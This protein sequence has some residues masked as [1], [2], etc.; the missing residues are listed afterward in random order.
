MLFMVCVSLE[1]GSDDLNKL[2]T[3][4]YVLV[5]NIEKQRLKDTEKTPK[6]RGRFDNNY[7]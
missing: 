5:A 3:C 4:Q 2:P 1:L 7:T 6:H